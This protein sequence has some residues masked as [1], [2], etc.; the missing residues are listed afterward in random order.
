MSDT[1]R[2]LFADPVRLSRTSTAAAGFRTTVLL[3]EPH[4]DTSEMYRDFLRYFRL[5]ALTVSNAR[6]ALAAAVTLKPPIDVV[7]TAIILPGE[8]DGVD[9]IAILRGDARTKNIGILALGTRAFSCDEERARA[10]GCDLFLLKPCLPT[11]LL[12]HVR[13]LAAAGTRAA[14]RML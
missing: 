2:R 3:V 13:G 7:V 14:D 5:S 8:L 12:Q 10:A 6:D 11:V 4:T 1:E 9:L